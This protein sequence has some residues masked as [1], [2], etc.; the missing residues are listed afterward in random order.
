MKRK[1]LCAILLVTLLGA[2]FGKPPVSGNNPSTEVSETNTDADKAEEY[3]T[4]IAS[5][6]VNVHGQYD[7]FEDGAFTVYMKEGTI[8]EIT[9]SYI[10][11]EGILTDDINSTDKPISV[12]YLLNNGNLPSYGNINNLD[13]KIVF[14]PAI[15][16]SM[17]FMYT[18]D[19]KTLSIYLNEGATKYSQYSTVEC[20]QENFPEIQL[21][22]EWKNNYGYYGYIILTDKD[23]IKWKSRDKESIHFN[24]NGYWSFPEYVSVS[25]Y[26][27][28][29]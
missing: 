20:T 7:I 10:L 29:N 11:A 19:H 28:N 23:G 15:P 22:D 17:D 1:L 8:C 21:L 2:G 9:D 3:L 24:E 26:D 5:I 16:F 13:E 14:T 18:G 4:A 6:P 25:P 27:E 12:K